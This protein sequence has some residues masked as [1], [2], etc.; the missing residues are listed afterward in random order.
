MTE[1]SDQAEQLI[2]QCQDRACAELQAG[3]ERYIAWAF[4]TFYDARGHRMEASRT[5]LDVV[6]GA[7]A[8][9]VWAAWAEAIAAGHLGAQALVD[10]IK[11]GEG[12]PPGFDVEAAKASPGGQRILELTRLIRLG[13][14]EPPA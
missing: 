3:L 1:F 5:E 10:R 7:L 14:M 8:L 13:E 12:P 4:S 9:V 6:P 11:R 2:Q